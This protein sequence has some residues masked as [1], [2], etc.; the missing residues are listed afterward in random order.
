MKIS[1]IQVPKRIRKNLGDLESLEASIEAV[2]LLHPVVIDE[3][4][5]LIAGARRIAA[6]Q[7]LGREN[8]PAVMVRDLTDAN[9]K[10]RAEGDENLERLDFAPTEAVA[11]K[12]R[13]EPILKAA[14]KERQVDAGKMHGRGKKPIGGAKLA[15]AIK[16]KTRDVVAAATRTGHEAPQEVIGRE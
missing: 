9:R 14:A 7:H 6:F 8:I 3:N 16:A 12:R 1:E 2:G 5:R 15:Q 11:Y 13:M 10:L 4:K